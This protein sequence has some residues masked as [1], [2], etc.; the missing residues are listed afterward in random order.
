[1]ELSPTIADAL[2]HAE[3]KA[4]ATTGHHG[5]NVVPVSTVRVEG[6]NILLMNY[7]LKKTLSNILDQPQVALAFWSKLEGYQIKGTVVYIDS[8][9]RF[10][11]AKQWVTENVS[12]RTLRGL[13]ILT[14]EEVCSVSP[15][16]S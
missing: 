7:F 12:N 1:M 13:L 3:S 2:L 9:V 14:P 4:L 16:V 5:V 15:S 6:G 10:E 11:E 8:G